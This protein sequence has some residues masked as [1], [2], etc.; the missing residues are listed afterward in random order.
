MTTSLDARLN[1]QVWSEMSGLATFVAITIV[2]G[3]VLI[4]VVRSL[5]RVISRWRTYHDATGGKEGGAPDPDYEVDADADDD[6]DLPPLP[7]PVTAA[8]AAAAVGS[9]AALRARGR[10]LE[11]KYAK[12]NAALDAH[13]EQRDA[14]E[15]APRDRMDARVFGAR[16][17][18]RWQY[19]APGV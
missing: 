19:P 5:I 10:Q 16:G 2:L 9:T 6:D 4:I 11:K 1:E 12:Y 18:E 3:V 13:L 17:A 7:T 8:D 14:S 15:R